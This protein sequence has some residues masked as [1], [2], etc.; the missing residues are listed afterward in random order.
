ME[1]LDK[2]L[3][4]DVVIFW[5]AAHISAA[6]HTKE[7]HARLGISIVDV[8]RCDNAD[9]LRLRISAAASVATGSDTTGVD[10]SSTDARREE[11]RPIALSR[12]LAHGYHIPRGLRWEHVH[13][14]LKTFLDKRLLFVIQRAA[15]RQHTIQEGIG[16][17]EEAF[18]IIV[19]NQM[20]CAANNGRLYQRIV[21][22]RLKALL[23]KGEFVIFT[24][25]VTG[26][27]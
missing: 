8:I 21:S 11:I 26:D 16:S 15:C 23:G 18:R 5:L 4:S 17:R 6:M 20:R 19:A 12:G 7:H 3:M 13:D 1:G 27:D 22:K 24:C 2:G 10:F 14:I 25:A 9:R